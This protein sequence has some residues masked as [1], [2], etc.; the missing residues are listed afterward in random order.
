MSTGTEVLTRTALVTGARRG[1]GRAIAL[2]LAR[3]ECDIALVD[4]P[5]AE[6]SAGQS[7]ID[8]LEEVRKEVEALGRKA[9]VIHADITDEE[10]VKSAVQNTVSALGG[11]DVMVANAGIAIPDRPVDGT[12]ENFERTMTVNVTGVLLCYKYAAIEMIKQGRGGRI[13]GASSLAGK[14]G[15]PGMLSYTAS[16]FAIRGITQSAAVELARHKITVNCY[17]PNAVDTPMLADLADH[18]AKDANMRGNFDKFV[19]MIPAGRV[20][21]PEEVAELV[22]FLASERAGYITGQ[23]ISI[24]GGM[25][26]D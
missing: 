3:D 14:L 17:A 11:L 4:L 2:C 1:I 16:K 24:N 19:D 6:G 21:K 23:T 13:L 20:G 9:L 26:M 10:A 8:P 22:C 7:T 25:H 5:P 12:R 15:T 18:A